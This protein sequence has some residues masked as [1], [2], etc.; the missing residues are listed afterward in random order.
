MLRQLFLFFSILGQVHAQIQTDSVDQLYNDWQNST[1]FINGSHDT[2][3]LQS[4]VKR[5]QK[6]CKS[7][8]ENA[9]ACALN[10]M[11]QAYYASQLSNLEG[12][13]M[14]KKARDELQHALELNPNVYGGDTYAELAYLYHKTPSWPFSFGSQKMAERLIDKALEVDPKGLITNLRCGE[15]W[16]DQK[17]Y[18]RAYSCFQTAFSVVDEQEHYNRADFLL[19]QARQMLAKMHQ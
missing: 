4:L 6:L 8:A 9:N 10:G 1:L 15:F 16:Y 12:V 5:G 18:I 3:T 14:A 13:K 2:S 17:D 7:Q 19:L 11:I